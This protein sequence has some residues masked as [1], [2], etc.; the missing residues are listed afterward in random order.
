MRPL[1]IIIALFTWMIS[2]QTHYSSV[3]VGTEA[4][5]ILRRGSKG[6]LPC[7]VRGNIDYV[8]WKRGSSDESKAHQIIYTIY[9]LD[10]NSWKISGPGYESGLY[11]ITSNFSLVINNVEIDHEDTYICV[12]HEVTANVIVTNGTNAIVI[13]RFEEK[14][15]KMPCYC[16]YRVPPPP[17]KKKNSP[18]SQIFRALL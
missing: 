6:L 11:N 7:E 9:V 10:I 4:Q 2:G 13:G 5:V 18:W 17:K 3:F 14:N 1:I 8:L 15:N 12:I 16:L